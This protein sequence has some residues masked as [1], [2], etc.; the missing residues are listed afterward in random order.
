M[1]ADTEKEE[2]TSVYVETVACAYSVSGCCVTSSEQYLSRNVSVLS[3]ASIL[4]LS[5]V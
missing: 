5:R 1:M 4:M 2:F 3:V